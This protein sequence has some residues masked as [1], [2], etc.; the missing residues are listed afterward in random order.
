MPAR[1][2]IVALPSDIPD[3]AQAVHSVVSGPRVPSAIDT[4]A[5]PM[6]AIR[7]V[8]QNGFSR[9]GPSSNSLK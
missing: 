5:A 7:A 1:M 4:S 9:W 6:F 8:T 3:A 2:Y